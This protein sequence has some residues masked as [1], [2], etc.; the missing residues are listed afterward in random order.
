[1][2]VQITKL[3][4]SF[5]FLDSELGRNSLGCVPATSFDKIALL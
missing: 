4:F 3:T 2:E 1:M 5:N